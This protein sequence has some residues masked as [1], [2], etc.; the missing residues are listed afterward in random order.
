LKL[1]Q[2]KQKKQT[3]TTS[4]SST[5]PVIL[6]TMSAPIERSKTDAETFQQELELLK[7]PALRSLLKDNKLPSSGNKEVLIQR[8]VAHKYPNTFPLIDDFLEVNYLR[9]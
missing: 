1:V 2:S 9:H 8:L 6:I 4:S 7:C 3:S 5:L